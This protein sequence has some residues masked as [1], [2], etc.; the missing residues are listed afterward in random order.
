MADENKKTGPLPADRRNRM[1]LTE[2]KRGN[3]D[4]ILDLVDWDEIMDMATGAALFYASLSGGSKPLME[5]KIRT[6]SYAM[7]AGMLSGN[8]EIYITRLTSRG[9]VKIDTV[10]K[11]ELGARVALFHTKPLHAY[12][13]RNLESY[14]HW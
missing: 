10:K 8:D 7:T 11:S 3:P 13:H 12:D 1:T 5:Q 9:N 14:E 4:I 6:A 2:L